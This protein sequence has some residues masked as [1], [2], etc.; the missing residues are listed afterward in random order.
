MLPTNPYVVVI[1]LDFSKAFDTVRHYTLLCSLA[2]MDIPNNVYNWIADFL[3]LSQH[4]H[5]TVYQNQVSV[6]SKDPQ[7]VQPRSKHGRFKDNI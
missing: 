5:N 4:S 3:R 1:A 7:L 6:L 2:Q